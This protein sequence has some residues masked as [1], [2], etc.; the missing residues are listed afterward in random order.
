ML[1]CVKEKKKCHMV[2]VGYGV[3]S[4]LNMTQLLEIAGD[5]AIL[6]PRPRQIRKMVGKIKKVVCRK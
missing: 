6:V 5:N 3:P 2:A 4:K 1:V